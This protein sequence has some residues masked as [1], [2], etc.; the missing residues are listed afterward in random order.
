MSQIIV[1]EKLLGR[2]VMRVLVL[3]FVAAMG[4]LGSSQDFSSSIDTRSPRFSYG[5]FTING[6]SVSVSYSHIGRFSYGYFSDGSRS[7][8]TK[9]GNRIYT[10]IWIEPKPS[11]LS[12]ELRQVR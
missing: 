1:V 4:S 9:I 6:E 11:K 5:T 7:T 3:L 12:R 8:T 10:D 2:I